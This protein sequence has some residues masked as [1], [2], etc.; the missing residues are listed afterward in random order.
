[1]ETIKDSPIKEIYFQLLKTS[2]GYCAINIATKEIIEKA[3]LRK[4]LISRL[5]SK[6]KKLRSEEN[7]CKV[8]FLSGENKIILT[9]VF[10][11]RRY[12]RFKVIKKSAVRRA[13]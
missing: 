7:E 6:L 1:M 4:E 3:S 2:D 10:K 8:Y 9:R 12:S 11:N 5:I 13:D